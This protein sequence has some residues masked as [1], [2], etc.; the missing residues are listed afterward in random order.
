MPE[1]CFINVL[2]RGGSHYGKL[3][4]PK[5]KVI[6]IYNVFFQRENVIEW[7]FIYCMY[8]YKYAASPRFRFCL[9]TQAFKTYTI[10]IIDWKHYHLYHI[11]SKLVI[12]FVL[13][14]YWKHIRDILFTKIFKSVSIYETAKVYISVKEKKVL[15]N[16]FNRLCITT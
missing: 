1:I 9:G 14:F 13:N 7:H 15:N 6:Y 4:D 2:F 10:L 12:T 16:I 3:W 5:N 8:C 11:S